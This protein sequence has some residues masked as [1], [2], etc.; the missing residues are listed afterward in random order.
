MFAVL[1][2]INRCSFVNSSLIRHSDFVIPFDPLPHGR[3]LDKVGAW[4][5]QYSEVVLIF[6]LSDLFFGHTEE[7]CQFVDNG[8]ADLSGELLLGSGDGEQVLSI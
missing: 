1:S 2:L 3:G 5:R 6:Q 7:V 4:K 8:F